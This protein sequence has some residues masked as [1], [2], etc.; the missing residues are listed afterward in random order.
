MK[1]FIP[2]AIRSEAKRRMRGITG[3]GGDGKAT[4]SQEGEDLLIARL[5][6]LEEGRLP[7]FY[8]DVGAHDPE[9]YS[10]TMFFYQRGWRGI[11]IDPAPGTAAKFARARPRDVNVEVA[12][13]ENDGKIQYAMFNHAALNGCD[14]SLA[15]SRDGK[16]GHR[17]ER[18]AAVDARRLDSILDEH[19]PRPGHI[20]FLSVDVEG[21]DLAVLRSNAWD[22]YRPLIVLAEDVAVAILDDVGKSEVAGY[23]RSVGYT[24]VAKCALTMVFAESEHIQRTSLG[25]R[26]R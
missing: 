2:G 11:N 13:A 1:R 15:A 20:D 8:V 4:F 18:V 25:V 23:M 19:L 14:Q 24:P 6:G 16:D 26:V 10:N 22:R 21:H 5:L 3:L 9:R 12:V 7:G 17:I